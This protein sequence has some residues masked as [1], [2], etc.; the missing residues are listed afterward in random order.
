MKTQLR[1]RLCMLVA[2]AIL[3]FAMP[4]VAQNIR[5]ASP[6]L[7]TY[8]KS[9]SCCA[10]SGMRLSM[11]RWRIHRMIRSQKSSRVLI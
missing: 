1:L 2:I 10:Q 3:A 4:S 11:R 5:C 6:K 8:S 7:R 9:V